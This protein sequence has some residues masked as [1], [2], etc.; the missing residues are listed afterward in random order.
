MMNPDGHN[1]QNREDE[2]DGKKKKQESRTEGVSAAD[3]L[4]Q[5][6]LGLVG[7]VE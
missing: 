2:D 5:L 4:S 3:F 1:G 7:N 6:R